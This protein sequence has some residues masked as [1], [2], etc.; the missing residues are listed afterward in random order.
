MPVV[1]DSGSSVTSQNAA[2]GFFT[3][4]RWAAW[5]LLVVLCG[6]S[7]VRPIRADGLNVGSVVGGVLGAVFWFLLTWS[8][9]SRADR[10]RV[11]LWRALT[12]GWSVFAVTWATLEVVAIARGHFKP[13]SLVLLVVSLPLL[14]VNA[15]QWRRTARG[16][17]AVPDREEILA[18]QEERRQRRSAKTD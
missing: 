2:H 11:T 4:H 6:G 18:R 12:L 16:L 1:T 5:I 8:W 3:D 9:M 7:V 14:A 17:P 15:W 13:L 10:D